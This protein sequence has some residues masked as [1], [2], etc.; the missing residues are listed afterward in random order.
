MLR[1]AFF[2]SVNE[3]VAGVNKRHDALGPA[4]L[5][6]F[7]ECGRPG[8]EER[9]ELARAEYER[10]RTQRDR[11][12]LRRGHASPEIERVVE[13]VDGYVVVERNDPRLEDMLE[14]FDSGAP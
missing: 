12:I 4:A 5:S 9:L 7:C 10:V 14:S 8:C 1:R 2:R 13:E 6:L 3:Q 11:F